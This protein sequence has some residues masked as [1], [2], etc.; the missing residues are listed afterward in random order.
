MRELLPARTVA[1]IGWKPLDKHRK[2]RWPAKQEAKPARQNPAEPRA[3]GRWWPGP[4]QYA[5]R[6]RGSERRHQNRAR[7]R[8]RWQM[9]C[10]VS[11]WPTSTTPGVSPPAVRRWSSGWSISASDRAC[12]F[13]GNNPRFKAPCRGPEAD[14]RRDHRLRVTTSRSRQSAGASASPMRRS[15][16]SAV[17]E[18][19]APSKGKASLRTEESCASSARRS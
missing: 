15:T 3:P 12:S 6:R 1:L 8:F 2:K 7:R 19:R 10:T 9:P 16:T 13:N 4:L 11:P 17:C 5:A 18:Q 14:S